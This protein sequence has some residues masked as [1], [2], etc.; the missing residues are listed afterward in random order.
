MCEG[1]GEEEG[2]TQFVMVL[3]LF[4]MAILRIFTT[5]LNL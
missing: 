1:E 5:R 2:G 3:S 4:A